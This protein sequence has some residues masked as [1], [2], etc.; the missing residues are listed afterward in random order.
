M[1]E[2]IGRE[3]VRPELFDDDELDDGCIWW[4]EIGLQPPDDKLIAEA[5]RRQDLKVPFGRN[6]GVRPED[7]PDDAPARRLPVGDDSDGG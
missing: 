4:W 2:R 7:S 1:T 5:E 6:L 3:H